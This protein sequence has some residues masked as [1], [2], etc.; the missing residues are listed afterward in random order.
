MALRGNTQAI[1]NSCQWEAK[2]AHEH[3]I[4]IIHSNEVTSNNSQATCLHQFLKFI[5]K[6]IDLITSLSLDMKIMEFS[7]NK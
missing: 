7:N 2:G 6:S 1:M 3:K 4:I 5:L